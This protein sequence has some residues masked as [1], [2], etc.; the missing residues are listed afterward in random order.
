MANLR[1]LVEIYHP[2][3]PAHQGNPAHAEVSKTTWAEIRRSL[4][5]MEIIARW[6]VVASIG[7]VGGRNR[8]GDPNLASSRWQ[9]RVGGQAYSVSTIQPYQDAN[10]R[11][12]VSLLVH[13]LSGLGRPIPFS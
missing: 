6:D 8:F 12:Y 9:V 7:V 10:P 2:D 13:S 11:Q 1:E 4:D 3:L 5:A